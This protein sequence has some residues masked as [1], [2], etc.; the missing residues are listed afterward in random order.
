MEKGTNA[1]FISRAG[2]VISCRSVQ[3]TFQTLIVKFLKNVGVGDGARVREVRAASR[4]GAKARGSASG[5][6]AGAWA[7]APAFLG[8]FTLS[9]CWSCTP[10]TR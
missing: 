10:R 4:A 1:E 3:N 2:S 6:A 9:G 8:A 5:V 7:G